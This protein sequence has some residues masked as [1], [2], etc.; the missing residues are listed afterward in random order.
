MTGVV[1]RGEI[2]GQFGT[3]EALWQREESQRWRRKASRLQKPRCSP[4]TCA[5]ALHR[6]WRMRPSP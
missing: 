2:A 4:R 5:S 1:E 6:A 3:W